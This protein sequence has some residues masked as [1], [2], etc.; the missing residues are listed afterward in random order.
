LTSTSSG[1]RN[2]FFFCVESDAKS[3][4]PLIIYFLKGFNQVLSATLGLPRLLV[5][6]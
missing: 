4:L 2:V 1:T 3:I 6:S 5:L